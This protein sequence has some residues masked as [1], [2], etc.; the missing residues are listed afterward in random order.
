MITQAR[1]KDGR[2]LGGSMGLFDPSQEAVKI[3]GP[4][5]NYGEIFAYLFRRF[6]YPLRGWDDYKELT[7]Y[8]LTT[9]MDGVVLWVKPN[10]HTILCF[11][12]MLRSDINAKCRFERLRPLIYRTK[13][14]KRWAAQRYRVIPID[15][16][17]CPG[18]RK[19]LNHAFL[20]WRAKN[21]DTDAKQFWDYKSE[22]CDRLRK[23]YRRH[24]APIPKIGSLLLEK[25]AGGHAKCEGNQ[26]LDRRHARSFNAGRYQRLVD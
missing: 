9:R 1:F 12:Y 22:Q 7:V 18:R 10:T 11:G 15:P 4:Y 3:F 17:Y 20:A 26:G 25:P 13:K 14:F 24:R 6:G 23:E 5:L 21:P 2:Y 8:Y 16:M 19:D